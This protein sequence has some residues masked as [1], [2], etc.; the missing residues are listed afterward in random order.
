MRK[1]DK[2]I[3]KTE[4]RQKQCYNQTPVKR[5][6]TLYEESEYSS[7]EN[8]LETLRIED[9][10][11]PEVILQIKKR[12]IKN[13]SEINNGHVRRMTSSIN[14]SSFEEAVID[15]LYASRHH[16]ASRV[17]T[18][19]ESAHAF[20]SISNS[21][22]EKGTSGIFSF[23]RW[24]RK[25]KDDFED[26]IEKVKIPSA[27]SSPRLIR[28][29][30]STCGSV[31]TLFSTATASSFAFIH[32]ELY[33]PF[34]SASQPEK[35]ITSGPE[36][37]TYR[38]RL[39]QRD[40]IRELDKNISLKKKYHLFGSGTIHRSA[41]D[42]YFVRKSN[43]FQKDLNHSPGSKNST[44]G[45]RKK[46]KAPPPPIVE[47]KSVDYSLPNTLE[48][49][50]KTKDKIEESKEHNH[51]NSRERPKHRRTVSD[52]AKDKKAGAYCHVRGKRKAP[53]PPTVSAQTETDNITASGRN[54]SS[55]KKRPAPPPP[56]EFLPTEEKKNFRGS[57][58][59]EDKLRLLN[60]IEKLKLHAE[61]NNITEIEP[62]LNMSYVVSNDSLKLEKGVL[63]ANKA[64][65]QVPEVKQNPTSP[66]SPRPWYKRNIIHK[67]NGK[68]LEKKKDKS[69]GND[70]MPEVGVPR[71]SIISTENNR[72]SNIFSRSGDEKR[73]SQIS[74]LVNISELDREAAEIVKRE[75]EKEKEKLEALNSKFYT[76]EPEQK[77]DI[78]SKN[79]NVE[80]PKKSSARELISLFNAIGNVT[81]VT[82]NSA[83]F[84][85]S[86]PSIFS[87]EGIEKRFSFVSEAHEDKVI[88]QESVVTETVSKN[89]GY[90]RE[91][92]LI[93]SQQTYLES[94]GVRR[95]RNFFKQDSKSDE[96]LPSSSTSSESISPKVT[97]E[98][99]DEFDAERSLKTK[100]MYEANRLRR[101][102]SPSPTIPTI[103]EMSESVNS[104]TTSPGST[105]VKNSEEIPSTTKYLSNYRNDN[106][107]TQVDKNKTITNSINIKVENKK[108]NGS[109][110]SKDMNSNINSSD[111]IKDSNKNIINLSKDE[112]ASTIN[113]DVISSNIVPDSAHTKS[114]QQMKKATIWSCP[115][116]TLENPR[117]RITCEACDMWRPS[118]DVVDN[119][120]ANFA[121]HVDESGMP[122]MSTKIKPNKVELQK[123]TKITEDIIASD[124]R[125]VVNKINLDTKSKDVASI[126]PKHNLLPK[127]SSNNG[128]EKDEFK[129]PPITNTNLSE[130]INSNFSNKGVSV[131]G[132]E[133]VISSTTASNA[134]HI[135]PGGST[136]LNHINDNKDKAQCITKSDIDIDEVRKARLAVFH[137]HEIENNNDQNKTM[138]V[139][140]KTIGN[141]N[142][143][144]NTLATNEEERLKIKEMLKEMKNSLPKRSKTSDSKFD[145][146]KIEHYNS[147]EGNATSQSVIGLERD[148]TKLGAIKK[149]VPQKNFNEKNKNCK[150]KTNELN[151]NSQNQEIAEIYLVKNE[152]T[153]EEIKVKKQPVEK[154]EK[155]STSV[156]TN[157]MVRKVE[158]V[159]LGNSTGKPPAGRITPKASRKEIVVPI[160]VEEYT[161]K[162]GVL[163]TSLSKERRRIGTGTF[164]LIR[165]R[166]FASIEATKTGNENMPV[167]VYA[168]VPTNNEPMP[169]VVSTS[170]T[171]VN[172]VVS[173]NSLID[174]NDVDKLTVELTRL[175]GLADFKGNHMNFNEI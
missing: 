114:P 89:N 61:K 7:D 156:Q 115:R 25:E 135:V 71:G 63:K 145:T 43:E 5:S 147:R 104:V 45:R 68:S 48:H 170:S 29:Y 50:S 132:T 166:D 1:K 175:K 22:K 78:I 23:F 53:P 96:N 124:N 58:S 103:A 83:F 26:E 116:C 98:E 47:P 62:N 11:K 10:N 173:N 159:P 54:S 117:W 129:Y 119:V 56:I 34:G 80:M 74:M 167:H 82:V 171:T 91:T 172:S 15:S 140:V 9:K 169:Q 153:I 42:V 6:S 128:K 99:I 66:V 87:K 20:L 164:E 33:R 157:G 160:T 67:E 76:D 21:R 38:K 69:K 18:H 70:W 8:K 73:N 24:F 162:D 163:Y 152:V 141:K 85:K 52:S 112:M 108:I 90:K 149:S 148:V 41:D 133:A 155:V 44:F 4:Q 39:W 136:N 64:E 46:R 55:K 60:N 105:I 12:G 81:K 137:K 106:S 110:N 134:L 13:V 51:Y 93:E 122:V 168:N 49:I 97:I 65:M 120:T 101:H 35:L 28:G 121:N 2:Y 102:H 84:S 165:P 113:K 154:P 86:G 30:G 174:T 158:S 88:V 109:I 161:I 72:F 92:T 95:R 57:L 107:N 125:I 75:Q 139:V 16:F 36:T 27:P 17:E 151:K 150:E 123:D 94:P 144:K 118:L 79:E 77:Q 14:G 32:P 111:D 40:K 19:S 100:D 131:E 138:E 142:A 127:T 146:S 59:P 31:D 130:I 143:K 126:V 3:N 37:E